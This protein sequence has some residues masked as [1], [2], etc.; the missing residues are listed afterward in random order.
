MNQNF[1]GSTFSIPHGV[2]NCTCSGKR[3]PVIS[4][5]NYVDFLSVTLH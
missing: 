1:S 3:N 5:G 2:V 4:L